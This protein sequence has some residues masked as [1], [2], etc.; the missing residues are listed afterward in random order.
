[1]VQLT[2]YEANSHRVRLIESMKAAG[3]PDALAVGIINV[4]ADAGFDH[5]SELEGRYCSGSN[6]VTMVQTTIDPIIPHVLRFPSVTEIIPTL[7]FRY[8]QIIADPEQK[9][10]NTSN[11]YARL[12]VQIHPEQVHITGEA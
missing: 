4:L 1:M 3:V 11:A 8:D 6:V 7:L 5:L 9:R 12:A 2:S 10:R